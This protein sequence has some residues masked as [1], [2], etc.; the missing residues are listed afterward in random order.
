LNGT[1]EL[2]N[3]Y[4]NQ[5]QI[6]E[7]LYYYQR[8]AFFSPGGASAEILLKVSDCFS[9]QGDFDRSVEYLDHAYF[10]NPSDSLGNEIILKKANAFIRSGN[11][12][13]ALIELLGMNTDD[14]SLMELRRSLYLGSTYYWLGDYQKAL[15]YFSRIIQNDSMSSSALEEIFDKKRNFRRPNPKVAMW[16]SVFIPGSGQIYAGN[17]S[18][19]LNSII[20]TGSLVALTIYLTRTYHP[21]D[22]LMTALPWFQRYYQGGFEQAKTLAENKLEKNRKE[23]YNKILEIIRQSEKH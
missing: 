12:N 7:A 14:N 11:Y 2:G 15:L 23:T 4:L 6:P 1:I 16:L 17:A 5:G 13:F 22:A 3:N 10:S 8:A 9:I 19:G 20:L 21:I 18:A